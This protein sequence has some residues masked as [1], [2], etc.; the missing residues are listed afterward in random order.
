MRKVARRIFGPQK[1]AGYQKSGNY[2]KYVKACPAWSEESEVVHQ[3][4]EDRQ[5][6]QAVNCADMPPYKRTPWVGRIHSFE[7]AW[8][9]VK[10][11][12][13]MARLGQTIGL[14]RKGD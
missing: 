1:N 13:K 7:L 5:S 14:L 11:M 8:F 10:A 9:Y 3:D 2:E 4:E 12:S 6:S